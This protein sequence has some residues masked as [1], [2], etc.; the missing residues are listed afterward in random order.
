MPLIAA[1][2][3]TVA[4]VGAGVAQSVVASNDMDKMADKAKEQKL[5]ELRADTDAAAANSYTRATGRL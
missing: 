1:V 3:A 4:S 2:V 5:A